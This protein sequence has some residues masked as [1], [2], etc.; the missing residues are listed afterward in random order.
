[1]NLSNKERDYIFELIGSFAFKDIKEHFE[2]CGVPNPQ[3][4]FKVSQELYRKIALERQ[5]ENFK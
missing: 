2:K 1:M 3:Q 4:Y 5:Q